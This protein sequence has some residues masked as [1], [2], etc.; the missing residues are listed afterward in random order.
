MFFLQHITRSSE[1]Q[2]PHVLAF[3]HIWHWSLDIQHPS[4]FCFLV[5]EFCCTEVL[6]CCIFIAQ[7]E[8]SQL[9]TGVFIWP[10]ETNVG[11]S[12]R[13]CGNVHEKACTLLL[14][15]SCENCVFKIAHDFM[16]CLAAK[17]AT[18]YSVGLHPSIPSKFPVLG[19]C[20]STVPSIDQS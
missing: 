18:T 5:S 4:R 11:L 10:A 3:E 1:A 6:H 8:H 2:H 17:Y 16:T 20:T 15:L 13:A 9:H 12:T 19:T 7:W 14:S